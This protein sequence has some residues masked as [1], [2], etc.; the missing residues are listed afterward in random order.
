MTLAG[1]V[2]A[3]NILWNF[4]GTGD[5]VNIFKSGTVAYG[6]FLAPY[7]N[8]IQDHAVVSGRY[9]GATGGRSLKIHS[10]ATVNCP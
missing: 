10:A 6:T 5:D 2:D 3:N 9:I 4:C 8:L 7:R 1:G